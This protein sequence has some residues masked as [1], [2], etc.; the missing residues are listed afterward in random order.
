M[1][2]CRRFL[3]KAIAIMRIVTQPVGCFVMRFKL[4]FFV[5]FGLG[6][7]VLY[8]VSR[9]SCNLP[10]V[11]FLSIPIAWFVGV[12]IDIEQP[13]Q[14]VAVVIPIAFS[15]SAVIYTAFFS[16][17][18]RTYASNTNI[19]CADNRIR[20]KL[21]L[22]GACYSAIYACLQVM[23][24]RVDLYNDTFWKHNEKSHS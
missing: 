23:Y 21:L 22:S 7:V 11:P 20:S 3:K 8:V 13:Y 18:I 24:T 9:T 1:S 15:F 12:F 6:A 19:L 17:K 4:L 16:E 2:S 10:H 14:F 5:V